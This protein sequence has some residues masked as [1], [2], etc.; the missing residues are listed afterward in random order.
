MAFEGKVL[1]GSRNLEEEGFPQTISQVTKVL[2]RL[3]QS[4]LM[5]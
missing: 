3:G 2:G 5:Y 4:D 1:L